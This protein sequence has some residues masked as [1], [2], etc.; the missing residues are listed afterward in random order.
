LQAAA[1]MAAAGTATGCRGVTS[2]W[3]F[4]S[5]EEAS[6]LQAI[7]DWIIPADQYPGAVRADVVQYIDPQLKGRFAQHGK[8]YREGLAAA[9]RLAG[10][11]A[12]A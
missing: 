8:T 3:R 2:Q 6:T 4:F 1:A 10:G 12:P 9:N 5:L 11:S 7:A